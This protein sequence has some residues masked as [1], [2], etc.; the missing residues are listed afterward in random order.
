MSDQFYLDLIEEIN[1][2]IDEFGTTYTIHTP[3]TYDEA[4]LTTSAPTTRTAVGLV[5]DSQTL[6]GLGLSSP[7][8]AQT[9]QWTNTRNLLLQ[10]SANIQPGE[11]VTVDGKVHELN[12]AQ[13]IKPANIVVLY[14]LDL[15]L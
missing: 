4:T 3:G 11:S 15:S 8:D 6:N 5:A 10:A 14:I 13:T 12:N 7:S 1:P 2:I 9:L